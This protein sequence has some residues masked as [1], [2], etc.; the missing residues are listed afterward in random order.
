MFVG[1]LAAL[2]GCGSQGD[3]VAKITTVKGAV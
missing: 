2:T 3:P 1:L